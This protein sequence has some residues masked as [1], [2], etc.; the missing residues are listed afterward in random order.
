[1]LALKEK[2]LSMEQAHV[3][4]LQATHQAYLDR[5]HSQQK[6]IADL[7]AKRKQFL[8]RMK[9]QDTA[10]RRTTQKI[11]EAQSMAEKRRMRISNLR[12]A[13]YNTMSELRQFGHTIA[14]FT[15]CLS[16]WVSYH[17]GYRLGGHESA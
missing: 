4:H 5:V 11:E 12:L 13:K 2:E 7:R 17:V 9:N 6:S 16:M 8:H 10:L 3:K 1:M 15:M 14:G